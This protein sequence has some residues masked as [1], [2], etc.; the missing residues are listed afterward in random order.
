MTFLEQK[1]I[2]LQKFVEY[3]KTH[4][5]RIFQN[6]SILEMLDD[7]DYNIEREF[8]MFIGIEKVDINLYENINKSKFIELSLS[9][10]F[11]EMKH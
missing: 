8:Y 3:L 4:Y 6:K 5:Y 10:I 11:S 1:Q 2:L 7:P 9:Y